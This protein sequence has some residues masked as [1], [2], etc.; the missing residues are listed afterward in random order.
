MKTVPPLLPGETRILEEERYSSARYG[1]LSEIVAGFLKEAE[2]GEVEAA[3]F[4][5]PGPVTG[6]EVRTPN[7]PW[8]VRGE[9]VAMYLTD[10]Q[11]GEHLQLL[12]QAFEN[13]LAS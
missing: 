4:G 5:V 6:A 10:V 2:A 7:L 13:A 9:E 1:G 3:C 12:S 11:V 8:I